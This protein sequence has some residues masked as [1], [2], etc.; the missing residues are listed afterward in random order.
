M[1]KIA[2][3]NFLVTA[4]TILICIVV[5]SSLLLIQLYRYSINEKFD[6]LERDARGVSY[7]AIIWMTEPYKLDT[8]AFKSVLKSQAKV[9][10]T[11]IMV[12]DERGNIDMFAD[13]FQDGTDGG[14]IS[15]EIISVL[16]KDGTYREIGTFGGYFKN[17]IASVALPLLDFAGNFR[18][19]VIISTPTS[20]ITQ[21]F[22]GFLQ[23]ILLITAFIL[24][25]SSALIYFISR[26]FTKPL[27][28]MATAA[29]SFAMGDFSARVAVSGADEIA[30]LAKSF[31]YMADS[32]EKLEKLRSEFIANVSHELK[33][34]MT[35]IG[36]FI[37]GILDGTIPDTKKEHYLKIIGDEVHRLSRLVSKLLLATRL[38]SGTQELNIT[39]VDICSII[40]LTVVGA[41]QAIEAKKMTVDINFPQSR[42]FVNGD[43][44]ALTQVMT[45]LVDNA[46]KYGNEE[47]HISITVAKRND[48]AYVTVFNTGMGISPEDLPYV[49]DRFY[50]VDRSRG[51]DKAST[52][53]G[54]YIVKSILKNLNQEIF[55]ES[56][57]GKWIRFTFTLEI[58]KFQSHPELKN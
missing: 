33:T 13:S 50:K 2:L 22:S 20:S 10:N 27:K 41:E 34:P 15:E 11:R 39:S 49:F 44:D 46:V 45:N 36:G 24:A 51:I 21:A 5:F 35:T 3:R 43:A 54:L 30:D 16:K 42:L 56:E 25:F 48:L 19:S 7:F 37:D 32:M 17:R 40:S 29:R 57:Y 38:Q 58:S 55:V 1:S 47:G 52:G 23:G 28:D 26:K 53:L 8:A 14:T 4:L 12:T 31:N 9:N 18:G 6:S